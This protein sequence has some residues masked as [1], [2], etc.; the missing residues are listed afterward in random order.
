M[1]SSQA[2]TKDAQAEEDTE[3]NQ[4]PIGIDHVTVVPS[5]F[6]PETGE[7]IDE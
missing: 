1:A 2:E 7:V 3:D 5:N 4:P 6:D